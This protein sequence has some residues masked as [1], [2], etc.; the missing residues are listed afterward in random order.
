MSAQLL[1][2]DVEGLIKIAPKVYT[3]IIPQTPKWVT[4]KVSKLKPGQGLVYHGGRVILGKMRLRHTE[5]VGETPS[6]ADVQLVQGSLLDI[7]A[8][9]S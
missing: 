5:H 4:N 7:L 6:L 1:N 3:D 8:G 9:G 2:I